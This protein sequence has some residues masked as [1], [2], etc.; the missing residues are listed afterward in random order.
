M[1]NKDNDDDSINNS[2]D[3]IIDNDVIDLKEEDQTISDDIVE[4]NENFTENEENKEI[5]TENEPEKTIGEAIEESEQKSDIYK[6][7]PDVDA[8]VDEIVR[9]ESDESIVVADKKL[10][11]LQVTK[12]KISIK[13]KIKNIFVSWWE[14]RPIRYGT[15]SALFIMFVAITL[16]PA[17]R[18]SI[19]NLLGIRVE[20]SMIIVDS[21]TGL[22]LKD[23][24][25]QLQDKTVKTNADGEVSFDELMLGDSSLII[26]K[27]GYAE[28]NKTIVLGLGSNPIGEQNLVATGEQYTFVLSDW[29]SGAS[30]TKAEASSGENSARSDENGKIVLTIGENSEDSTEVTISAE[31]Y[32]QEKSMIDSLSTGDN[33]VK[34]VPAKK[35]VFVSKRT[36]NYDLYTVDVDSQNEKLLIPATDKERDVPTVTPHPTK[37]VVAYTSTRE[38]EINKEGFIFDALFI[39]DSISGD[40]KRVARSEQLQVIGWSGDNVIYLQIV[41]GTSAGNDERSKLVSYNYITTERKDLASANYFNDVELVGDKL[42]YAVSSFAVPES[43]AKLY[44]INTNGENRNKLIDMQVWNIFRTTYDTLIFSA[45]DQKWFQE[46]SNK[47]IEE[48]PKQSSPTS[49]NFV[50]SPN[51]ERVVW[52]DIRDGK[53]VLLKWS[54]K[55]SKEEQILSKSGLQDVLYWV[56]DSTVVLRIISNDETADYVLNI[57]SKEEMQKITDVT[58]TVNSYF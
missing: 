57:D 13:Q 47:A 27:R 31:N 55:D 17:T 58:A 24:N 20:S 18:Y 41:E 7:D 11:E 5:I 21:Q 14:N 50:A 40:L 16:F 45:V 39:V 32:R 19:L 23:I 22:P 37:D 49:N 9:A 43:Q 46:V 3:E 56:N 36:G 35:H 33:E 42:Y 6:S 53:G 4:D 51:N 25:V 2:I 1:N 34:M 12:S 10:A 48:I 54:T 38:G 29:K 30:I 15:L 52:V 26:T 8:A 44:T 28:N